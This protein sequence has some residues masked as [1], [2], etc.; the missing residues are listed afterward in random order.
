MT[1]RQSVAIGVR[2]FSVWL[3]LGGLGSGYAALV[4]LG[5]SHSAG[6]VAV[7]LVLALAWILAAAALWRFPQ[8][9]ARNLIPDDIHDAPP[10]G[11][12]PPEVWFATG[13]ALIGVWV[14]VTSLPS[15]IQS[16]V[17]ASPAVVFRDTDVYL[18]VRIVLGAGLILGARRLRRVIRWTRN[19]GVRPSGDSGE[20]Q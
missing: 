11:G 16:V 1:P 14:L 17:T 15:L 6:T 9:I 20:D 10:S 7:G 12:V 8:A 4:E 5:M 2:L 18:L 3:L 19:A 13:C